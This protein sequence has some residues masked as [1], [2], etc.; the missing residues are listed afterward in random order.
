MPLKSPEN[1]VLHCNH[2]PSPLTAKPKAEEVAP[3][4]VKR[5]L[6][7]GDSNTWGYLGDTLSEKGNPL[8]LPPSQ[9]WTGCLQRELGA[10]Y[11]VIEEGLSG[12]TVLVSDPAWAHES[13]SRAGHPQLLVAMESHLPVDL[14]IYMLGTN[15]CREILQLSAREIVAQILYSLQQ[16]KR[17]SEELEHPTQL[18]CLGPLCI[19]K[20]YENRPVFDVMG[21]GCAEKSQ[22]LLVRLALAC[23]QAQIP[24]FDIN[25]YCFASAGDG[26]HIDKSC[27]PTLAKVLAEPIRRLL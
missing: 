1:P 11:L 24:F 12:R 20:L 9:R 23:E 25:P 16:A 17:F 3:V 8:R 27:H 21:R 10:D 19:D 6:C 13:L 18:L 7:F 22:E 26:L 5:L 15:D 2:S 4:A 14:L